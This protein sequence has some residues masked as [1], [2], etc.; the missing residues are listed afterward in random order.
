MQA[1]RVLETDGKHTEIP[2]TPAQQI[3]FLGFQIKSD[4]MTISLPSE[5]GRKIQQELYIYLHKLV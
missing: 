2:T 5:K 3:E 4:S 1:I